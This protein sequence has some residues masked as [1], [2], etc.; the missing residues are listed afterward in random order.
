MS[1]SVSVGDTLD[2]EPLHL[3]KRYPKELC[4]KFVAELRRL[5]KKICEQV[6]GM[7]NPENFDLVPPS[8]L[9][10]IN[11]W[12]NQVLVLGCN[13]GCYDLSLI[14]E[15][16][17]EQ[18]VGSEGNIKVAKNDNKN[19]YLLTKNFRFLDIIIYLGSGTSYDKWV[20]AYG[21]T[22]EKSWFPYEWFDFPEKLD[23]SG[24][25]DYPA[26]YSHLREKFVLSL[27]EWR[28]CKRLFKE[29]GMKTFSNNDNLYYA[30]VNVHILL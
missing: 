6:R 1:I 5:G 18:I 9:T 23:F 11:D 13:S 22:A 24:L 8:H 15:H 4:L 3:Y 27:S 2:P 7:F 25:P 12:C 29:K 17:V 10:K 16:F 19:K 20:K 21:C 28:Q 14:K 26:W 30:L